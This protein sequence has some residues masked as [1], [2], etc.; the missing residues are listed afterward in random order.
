MF[1]KG[2]NKINPSVHDKFIWGHLPSNFP[3]RSSGKAS[4]NPIQPPNHLSRFLMFCEQAWHCTN[5]CGTAPQHNRMQAKLPWTKNLALDKKIKKKCLNRKNT[6]NK[7][8][9]NFGMV[10]SYRDRNGILC[11][12]CGWWGEKKGLNETATDIL[13]SY[14]R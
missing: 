7:P 2:R 1:K 5:T 10:K 12:F 13:I 9:T 4:N 11:T 8:V 3:E 14:K 6:K